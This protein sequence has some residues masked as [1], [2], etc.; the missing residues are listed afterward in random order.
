VATDLRIKKCIESINEECEILV[1]AN[2]A[3]KD[4]LTLLNNLKNKLGNLTVL[5][6]PERNLGW[7]RDVGI[8]NAQN[9]RILLMDSD[10]IFERDTIRKL[11]HGLETHKIAKGR[12]V[13]IKNGFTSN[14]IKEVRDFTTSDTVTAYAPPL[15][16]K[17]EIIHDIG[18]YYFDHDIHWVDDAELNLRV[19]THKI[20][21][22]YIPEAVI[23]HPPLTIY[24]DLRSAFRYGTG[25][26][27]GVEKGLMKGVGAF[28]RELPVVAKEKGVLAAL[29]L[30]VWN[31]VYSCA[32]FLQPYL[33]IY[34]VN[35]KLRRETLKRGESP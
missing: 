3:T 31:T 17:K 14:I 8:R 6:L 26:R 2:G 33:D 25:K 1:V 22:N 10:C 15:A 35:E 27:I 5:Q 11:Y 16:L 18:G 13:F 28:W 30:M 4:V 9:E 12:V 19:K 24:E 23:C 29:Y 7:A 20:P 21:I 34:R 32:F